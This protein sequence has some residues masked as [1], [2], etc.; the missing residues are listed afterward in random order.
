MVELI[1][2]ATVF[3]IL[4]AFATS[5]TRDFLP[6]Q[7]LI[8]KSNEL[9]GFL[10]MARGEAINLGG[11]LICSESSSCKGFDGG[12]LVAFNDRNHNKKQDDDEPAI[13]RVSASP[14]LRIYRHGWGKQHFL[15]YDRMGRLHYQNGHFL[16]CHSSYG[17]T[18]ILNWRGR[19]R[20]GSGPAPENKCAAQ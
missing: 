8:A 13:A 15:E 18:L 19:V 9:A 12:A 4:A 2:A 3:A 17:I 5:F 11:I 16:I 14:E 7:R 10:R 20:R 1:A 6:K